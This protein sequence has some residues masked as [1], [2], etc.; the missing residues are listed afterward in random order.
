MLSL[1]CGENLGA[2]INDTAIIHHEETS[3]KMKS[4]K[5]EMLFLVLVCRGGG[6]ETQYYLIILSS[7]W[8]SGPHGNKGC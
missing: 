7:F 2:Y 1:Q 3:N 6:S 5:P 4:I 8:L